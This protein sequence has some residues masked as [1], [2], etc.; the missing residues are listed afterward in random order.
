MTKKNSKSKINR[1]NDNQS[2]YTYIDKTSIES[3]IDNVS[4]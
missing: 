2:K 4:V 1:K 3:N